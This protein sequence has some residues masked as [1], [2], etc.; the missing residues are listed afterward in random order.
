MPLKQR[1]LVTTLAGFLVA[2]TACG[3]AGG[4]QS[5]GDASS[6]GG[7]STTS[8]AKYV[9]PGDIKSSGV[10]RLGAV[11]TSVGKTYTGPNGQMTG[12]D[13]DLCN[14]I[15]K[16][17][18]ASVTYSQVTVD[19][20]ITA[21]QAN[22]VDMI[23]TGFVITAARRKQ[24]AMVPTRRVT[25][26]IATEVSDA[27]SVTSPD[28]LCG[29]AVSATLGGDSQEEAQAW[30]NDC[31]AAGKPPYKL[32]F[33]QSIADSFTAVTQGR[34]TGVVQDTTIIQ[35]YLNKDQGAL[36]MAYTLPA[37][38]NSLDGFMFNVHNTVLSTAVTKALNA[39]LANG[40]YAQI[41]NKWKTPSDLKISSFKL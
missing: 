17:F 7:S 36:K 37:S 40:Q 21:L 29:K 30:S 26:G 16:Q 31:K 20:A 5:A 41:M 3:S 11:L 12:L 19:S 33:F 39:M 8:R 2:L 24:V 28:S 9:L 32:Q 10:L 27:A 22:R 1:I 6:S 38:P 34:A 13:T 23:C 35:Y 14:A 25:Y 18:G 4:G 15:A